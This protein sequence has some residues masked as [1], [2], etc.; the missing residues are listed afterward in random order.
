MT[1]QKAFIDNSIAVG[2]VAASFADTVMRATC[3][4]AIPHG[5]DGARVAA[6]GAAVIQLVSKYVEAS[7]MVGLS[8]IDHFVVALRSEMD[9]ATARGLARRAPVTPKHD[10]PT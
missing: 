5:N 8:S 3:E 7:N 2:A 9:V 4:E 1:S 10:I 6:Y